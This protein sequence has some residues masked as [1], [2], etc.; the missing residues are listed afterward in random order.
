MHE[1]SD[2][3]GVIQKDSIDKDLLYLTARQIIEIAKT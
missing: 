1:Q 2:F 3:E